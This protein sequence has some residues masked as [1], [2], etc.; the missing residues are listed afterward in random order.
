MTWLKFFLMCALFSGFSFQ[1]AIAEDRGR[2]ISIGSLQLENG[3]RLSGGEEVEFLGIIDVQRAISP[4]GRL[5]TFRHDEQIYNADAALFYKA[6]L[7]INFEI[8]PV[9]GKDEGDTA[10]LCTTLGLAS[11]DHDVDLRKSDL[12][13]HIKVKLQ[14]KLVSNFTIQKPVE[15]SSY[16]RSFTDFCI[17]GLKHSKQYEITIMKGFKSGSELQFELNKD[18]VFISKTPQRTPKIEL[19]PAQ[20][21][22]PNRYGAIIPVTTTNV[23]QFEVSLYRLDLRT[24]ASYGELFKSINDYSSGGLENFWGEHLGTRKVLPET[25]LNKPVSFNLNLQPLLQDVEPGM[26]VAVFNSEDLDLYG[27]DK[28][29][30]QWFMISDVAVSLYRGDQFTD[31]FLTSFETNESIGN[32]NVEILAANNKSLF[33]GSTNEVGRVRIETARLIGSGGLKPEFLVARTDLSDIT[34]MQLEELKS[35]PR[36]LLGGIEK[37]HSDDIY[38]TTDRDIFRPGET[39]NV[40][41]VA[42]SRELNA[43]D[44]KEYRL[45]LVRSDGE[46]VSKKIIKT[47]KNG[48]FSEKLILNATTRLGRYSLNTTLIDGTL[49]ASHRLIVDDFVPLTI[50]PKVTADNHLWELAQ[51]QKLTISAEYFSGGSA[52]LLEGQLSVRVVPQATIKTEKLSDYKFGISGEENNH[53]IKTIDFILDEN[54]EAEETLLSTYNVEKN[55]LYNVLVEAAV[56]DV[57]GRANKM[58]LE[59]PL[60]TE[61]AYLGVYSQLGEEIDDGAIPSFLVANVDRLGNELPID[62]VRY[63]VRKIHYRYNWYESDGWR[64]RRVKVGETVV[65]SGEVSD[66]NLTLKGALEWGRYELEVENAKGFKTI[67][68]FYSGWAR[69]QKPI[70]EPEELVLAFERKDRSSGLLKFE[71]P[72]AGKLRLLNA[73]SDIIT[74]KI[75]D[76]VEGQNRLEASIAPNLEPGSH[77]LATLMRPVEEGSEH[78]PQIAVGST[79]VKTISEK[80]RPEISISTP[81]RIGSDERVILEA[82]ITEKEGTALFFLVDEGLHAVT[83]YQNFDL[84]EHFLGKREVALG[85][86]TNFG[87]LIRQDQSLDQYRVGGGDDLAASLGVDKSDFFKTVAA[88]SG[89]LELKDGKV[90]FTFPPAGMEGRLRL[91]A[92]IVTNNGVGFEEKEIQVQDS[93]SLDISL[94]RFIAAGDKVY[95]KYA[96]RSNDFDGPV[97]MRVQ[98][99]QIKTEDQFLIRQGSKKVDLLP[100]DPVSTGFLPVRFQAKYADKT[101]ERDFELVS[102]LSSYPY[103]EIHSVDL[104]DP[105]WLGRSSTELPALTSKAFKYLEGD[106]I[107]VS[108][109]LSVGFGANL[110]QVLAALDR[111]PYG[112]IEQTSSTTRGLLARAGG[113]KPDRKLKKKINSGIERIIAKQKVSGAFGYWD[114]RGF[115]YDE[116]QP[117]AIETLVQALPYAQDR[118]KVVKSITKG[119]EYLYRHDFRDPFIQLHAYGLLADAGY[120]VTSRARYTI[121]NDIGLGSL[122]ELIETGTG[123]AFNGRLD[124]LTLAYWVASKLNDTERTEKLSGYIQ[125]LVLATDVILEPKKLQEGLWLASTSSQSGAYSYP[126]LVIE[127]ATAPKF[128]YLMA[129][130]NQNYQ[131]DLTREIIQR[132]KSYLGS[133]KNRSTIESARLVALFNAQKDTVQIGEIFVNGD[134]VT[135]EEDGSFGLPR[136]LLTKGF[137]LRYSADVPLVLNAEL[138]GRRQTIQSINNGFRIDKYWHDAEGNVVDLSNGVLEARQGDLF[139]VVLVIEATQK[140]DNDDL[141]VTDLLPSGFEIEDSLIAPPKVSDGEGGHLY[142]DLNSGKKAA[143][144]QKMDDRIIAHYQ[145]SWKYNS[146][147]ILAYTVRAAYTGEMTIPDAHAEHMYAPEISGRS[148]VAR[149]IVSKK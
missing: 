144:V 2:F 19:Q 125:R 3:I 139:T 112:C 115:V 101:I 53:E 59:I 43:I 36:V 95:G 86:Q 118:E 21:I 7:D 64:W 105:N 117:Y 120:E 52:A 29:P 54:G 124:Q 13:G 141:L 81:D 73:G 51:T 34:V 98:V 45:A 40:A 100:F 134:T 6:G 110:S 14:E 94:P 17:G 146:H 62:G 70:S 22:L 147:A 132:T 15:T 143:F 10:A 41:G 55:R 24:M 77:L 60:Q 61:D 108:F 68:S 106:H 82:N 26:F 48:V 129:D 74:S 87:K 58:R 121:D 63:R 76:V 88:S 127:R 47:N 39:I 56:M 16:S 91:V 20:N 96:A 89:M 92:L 25:K 9:L 46:I 119:L 130:L 84:V 137:E 148:S 123:A 32:A 65:E 90:G 109:N 66:K 38:L 5:A 104:I 12:A 135:L 33:S 28:R 114:R 140:T 142:L 99:G 75:F 31:V 69:D 126:D 18:L 122:N 145:D 23:E 113:L 42:R 136:E 44:E 80:R 27:Y 67:F 131:S 107:N 85:I 149:A 8:E 133:K 103:T 37:Q 138:S 57:G 102:R 72:F 50:E 111:Y 35:K 93:V 4:S 78:L 79:W 83:G 30:T 116:Y 97:K 49:L 1:G 128:A 71:A 11:R